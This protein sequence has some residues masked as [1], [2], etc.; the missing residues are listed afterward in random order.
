M[1]ARRLPAILPSL[2]LEEALEATR[3]WSAAGLSRGLVTVRP[4]RAPHHTISVPG[5]T[6]GGSLP[7]PGELSLATHGVLYLEELPEFRR[8]ALEALREPVE[9]GVVTVVRQR[10]CET[11]PARF[12]LIASMNPCACGWHGDP[13]GRC[14]CTP[15]EVRRYWMKLSGPLIDRFASLPVVP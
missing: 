8:E 6:G 2:T 12:V 9:E 14:R 5:L 7:R 1:L 15:Q 11:F 4:F 10:A 3:V 13:R